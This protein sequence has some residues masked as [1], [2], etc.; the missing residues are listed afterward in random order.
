MDCIKRKGLL[1]GSLALGKIRA[2]R[3]PQEMGSAQRPGKGKEMNRRHFL[4][5]SA[6][7]LL[8]GAGIVGI[9]CRGTPQAKVMDN[10][11]QDKVGTCAAGAETFKPMIEKAVGNLLAHNGPTIQTTG[12]P[13]PAA[14][15]KKICFVGLENKSSEELG[16]FKDQI[17]Q[18]IDAKIVQSGTFQPISMRF[19]QRGL[20][21]AR[22]RPDDLF[23]P[24][25]RRVFQGV[26]EQSGQPFDYLL[27]A[28]ITS[29]TTKGN[30]NFQRDY[31]LT[32]E[33]IDIQTGNP[34]KETAEV[35]KAYHS[36]RT[37][38]LLN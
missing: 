36:S 21:E 38:M 34:T 8:G 14:P 15:P 9:G 12:G 6:A 26:M 18:I 24:D 32:L 5:Q 30:G 2:R 16:D 37:N 28:T 23:M 4:S 1:Y 17:V 29:G 11:A 22:L 27:F 3:P 19:V 35:R 33:M 25:R 10:C 13:A 20:Q 31:L 7:L